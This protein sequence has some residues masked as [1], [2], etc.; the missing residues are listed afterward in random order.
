MFPG[1]CFFISAAAEMSPRPGPV[2]EAIAQSYREWFG[3]LEEQ[4]GRAKELGEIDARVD[5]T[6][7]VFELNGLM[8]A[9]NVF[10]FLFEDAAELER[11]RA[12]CASG[13]EIWAKA[14]GRTCRKLGLVPG[15]R[16]QHA[17]TSL[18]SGRHTGGPFL[19]SAE[20]ARALT[21]RQE[22]RG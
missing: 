16:P 11:A 7:L 1:G 19:F 3:L 21:A 9:A 13:W 14:R 22:A 4:A 18:E 10:F 20:A 5:T 17:G 6:Q 8:I 12:A 2:R 15:V